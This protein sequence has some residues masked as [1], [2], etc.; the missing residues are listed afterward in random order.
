MEQGVQAEEEVE[1]VEQVVGT[2]VCDL[3]PGSTVPTSSQAGERPIRR[4]WPRKYEENDLVL[5]N[6]MRFVT[7]RIFQTMKQGSN[8][9]ARR[10]NCRW[11]GQLLAFAK[12]RLLTHTREP[13]ER[14]TCS[15]CEK[16]MIRQSGW[17]AYENS[18]TEALYY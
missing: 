17:T 4:L 10:T 13:P 9:V 18:L 11:V 12:N 2:V 16:H 5:A 6:A 3:L 8:Q 15:A 1:Q 14:W 7:I